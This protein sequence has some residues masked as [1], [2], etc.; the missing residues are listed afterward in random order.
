MIGWI[1][2]QLCSPTKYS[3]ILGSSLTLI[4]H[5]IFN[6]RD[7]SFYHHSS[8]QCYKPGPL[9]QNMIICASSS[10]DSDFPQSPSDSL[11]QILRSKKVLAIRTMMIIMLASINCNLNVK[12]QPNGIPCS[13]HHHLARATRKLNLSI[14]LHSCTRRQH[15]SS[16]VVT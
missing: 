10:S 11:L 6:P 4:M 8:N 14:I 16:R 7:S 2:Y 3:I 12:E 15:V 5:Y 1:F 9:L 13:S